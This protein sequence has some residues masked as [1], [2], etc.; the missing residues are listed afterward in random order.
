[1]P[2]GVWFPHAR[3]V[4]LRSEPAERP[5]DDALVVEAVASAVSH[6]TEMLVYR[7]NVPEELAL[8]L[9]TLRGSY[10][11]PIK[12]GYASVGRVAAAGA[13]VRGIQVGDHVFVHHPHQDRYTVAAHRAVRLPEGLPP[14]RGVFLANLE[15]AV[16][17]ALDTHPRIG[18][19]VAVF[20]QG[21]VGL[22]VTQLLRRAGTSVLAVDPIAA[23]R[24][25]ALQCGADAVAAPED[26]RALVLERT[27]GRGADAV[28]EVSGSAGALQ[29]A[30][31]CAAFQAPVVVASWYGTKPVSLR[32]GGSF[33]RARLRLVSSQ[34]GHLDPAL[35]PRWDTA[36]RL[37]LARDL[38][39]ELVLD[40]LVTHRI[41]FRDAARAYALVDEHP[42]ETVQVVLT[43][44]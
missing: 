44:D 32:L 15:T 41:P 10:A 26:A 5:A 16:N 11:F 25:L 34:V 6:G 38:L 21:V 23:R 31:E 2:T 18:E 17:V 13:D 22:L 1:M 9:P 7:G 33:H 35:A 43:Y 40:P 27:A 20:G 30:I 28:V 8:D 29:E 42:E 36:R 12:F 37:A 4:E 39:S 14:E 3:A 24:R 19:I